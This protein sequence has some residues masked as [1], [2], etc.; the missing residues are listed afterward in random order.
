MSDNN[1]W[2]PWIMGTQ[3][4]GAPS[5]AEDRERYTEAPFRQYHQILH[6]HRYVKDLDIYVCPRAKDT[7]RGPNAIGPKS[8]KGYTEGEDIGDNPRIASYYTARYEDQFFRRVRGELF[9][10]IEI[11]DNVIEP[12]YTEY[13]FNDW[14]KGAGGGKIPALSGN[15][16]TQIPHPAYAVMMMDAVPENPRHSGGT[17]NLLYAD[18]HVNAVK[19]YKYLDPN[20]HKSESEGG[21]LE[22]ARDKDPFGNRPYWCWG[23]GENVNGDQ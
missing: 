8:I 14:N 15:M 21:G 22:N 11:T 16:I 7:G 3:R 5:D 23:L 10:G 9:P 20:Y 13:W 2:I 17:A 1:D 12:I 6:L 19:Q 18:A 4:E